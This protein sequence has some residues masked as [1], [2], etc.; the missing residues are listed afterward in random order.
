MNFLSDLEFEIISHLR[1]L[2][3]KDQVNLRNRA[4]D[5]ALLRKLE[6]SAISVPPP[7]IRCANQC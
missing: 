5:L 7:N 6:N 4:R 1:T 2:P 3:V